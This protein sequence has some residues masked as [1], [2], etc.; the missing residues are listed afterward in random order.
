ML[1]ADSRTPLSGF[2]RN[3]PCTIITSDLVSEITEL[4]HM[5]QKDEG[6]KT[7]LAQGSAHC[8]SK[9]APE[10]LSSFSVATDSHHIDSLFVTYVVLKFTNCV[11]ISQFVF[12]FRNLA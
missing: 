10:L 7:R 12:E 4:S 11:A 6:H 3:L 9:L 8:P 1:V 2:F 5:T